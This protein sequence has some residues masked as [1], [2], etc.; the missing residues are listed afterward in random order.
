MIHPQSAVKRP[1]KADYRP[2]ELPWLDVFVH[3]EEVLVVA[4]Q[5]AAHNQRHPQAKG[6]GKGDDRGQG[7]THGQL[8]IL[9]KRQ[10]NG[11]SQRRQ[12]KDCR[13]FGEHH[14][15]KEQAD[16]DRGPQRAAQPGQPDS[17][18][19][20]C[21]RERGQHRLQNGQ[22]AEAVKKGAGDDQSQGQQRHP[23]R[24]S[25]SKQQVAQH[26][27]GK[28]EGDRQPARGLDR[29]SGKEEQQPL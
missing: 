12:Q 2:V 21:E 19:Q 13:G 18:I 6:D 24:P 23:A 28:E 1:P 29:N 4:Q 7:A 5:T 17:Q 20:G 14:Q 27:I 25:G 8:A 11:P 3:K 22:A 10:Q 26:E 9:P 15:G 16:P